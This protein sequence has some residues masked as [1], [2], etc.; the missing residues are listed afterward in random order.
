MILSFTACG[1]K[2]DT[3]GS[4]DDAGSSTNGSANVDSVTTVDGLTLADAMANVVE[5]DPLDYV[6]LSEYKGI[7]V[8]TYVTDDEV[9]EEI[10]SIITTSDYEQI[11]EGEVK[12]GDTVNIDF[13]GKKDGVEFD[14]GSSEAF[15]LTI[16]SGNFIEGFEDGLIGKSVGETVDLD[17]TFPEGYTSEDLAGQA[18]VFTV[19][20]NYIRGEQIVKEFTDEFV[21]EYSE[22]EYTTTAS[23]REYL[24]DKLVSEKKD[25][26]SDEVFTTILK[27]ST[28][29]ECPQFLIDLMYLRL[30]ASYRAM[31]T[32]YGFEDFNTFLSESFKVTPEQYQQEMLNMSNT[33]VEQQLITE[34]L[35]AAENLTYTD[36]EYA[37]YLEDYKTNLKIE[38]NEEL[39][40]YVLT[41][42]SSSLD[43]LM[44]EALIL[45]KVLSMVESNAVEITEEP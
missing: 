2:E 15:D 38:T 13:V 23:Y 8:V 20:I 32:S 11:K 1:S 12:T 35:A 33:Y 3:S 18:V 36:D 6:T 30:D 22:G 24:H 39:E 43:T 16:G 9:E 45:D 7:E 26:M 28:V 31:A 25:A 44:N 14:G 19:T 27:E 42:Y 34:A 29:S 40:A 17:L 21:E 5:Y 41:N 10:T 37:A 4:T